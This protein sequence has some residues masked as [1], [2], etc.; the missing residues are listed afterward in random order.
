MENGN[1]IHISTVVAGHV[2][3]GKSTF[4]GRLIFERGGLDQRTLDKLEAEARAL[5]K[6]SFKYAFFTDNNKEER[7]RGITIN[8]NTKEFFTDRYHYSIIDAPGHRDFVKNMISGA[9]NADVG[10]IMVPSDGFAVALAK[11]NKDTGEVEGQTRQHAFLLN[12]L[13]VKQI[14][15][16][17]NKMDTVGYSQEK[18]EEI[19]G[20]VQDMLFKV[21]WP[22]AFVTNSVPIIPIS[23]WNG[24]NLSTHS[25][26]MPW[27]QGQTVKTVTGVDVNVTTLIDA[28]D[29]FVQPPQRQPDLPVRMPVSGVL[30]IKG[31]GDVITGRVEQGTIRKDD[32]IVFL[33][34]NTS[35]LECAGK[36]FSIEMHHKEFKEAGPGDNVGLNVKGLK[37]ENMPKVGDVLVLKSDQTVKIPVRFT[38]QVK[39]IDHQGEL[40]VG[41][42]PVACVRTSKAAIKM[43]AINWRMNKDTGN[44]KSENPPFVKAN[45]M[46][47]VVF[48]AKPEKPLI[49]EDFKKCEGLGR[50][51]IFEGNSVVMLGKVVSVEY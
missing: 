5:G 33:P 38:A 26:A 20:E 1:K 8:C 31:V 3:A 29:N 7:A 41:Y 23:A 36:V 42:T 10:I 24:D 30:K 39:V 22:K 37:K 4:T 34:R 19:K 11:A 25:N 40:K 27:Y 9:S 43:V 21:G 12:V 13:G 44:K 17:V 47:E 6:D 32:Q 16:C 14:I 50:L 48:E 46:A 49:V 18:F 51:A 28:L 2:D 15:I 45:D 35:N